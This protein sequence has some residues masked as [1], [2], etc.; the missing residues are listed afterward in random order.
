MKNDNVHSQNMETHYVN[1]KVN[2]YPPTE[3]RGG[4]TNTRDLA[5]HA[6]PL[7]AQTP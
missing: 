6:K 2:V 1:A 5:N 7:T 3:L 4:Y